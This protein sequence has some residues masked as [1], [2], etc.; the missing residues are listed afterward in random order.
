MEILSNEDDYI[1]YILGLAPHCATAKQ[2]CDTEVEA[3]STDADQIQITALSKAWRVGV[4]IAYLDASP[5]DVAVI[6]FPSDGVSEADYPPL[7]T[8]LYR[9]GHYDIAYFK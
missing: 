5:G 9:P 4:R 2:F 3:V 1:P 8:L 7:V 6:Q